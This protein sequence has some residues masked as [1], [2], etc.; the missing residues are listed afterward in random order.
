MPL[1]TLFALFEPPPPSWQRSERY[2]TVIEAFKVGE[3]DSPGKSL[4]ARYKLACKQEKNW[5]HT[6]VCPICPNGL[7]KPE[8]MLS[9]DCTKQLWGSSCIHELL[10]LN[11]EC[12]ICFTENIFPIHVEWF[13][14]N[15]LEN[16][17]QLIKGRRETKTRK[18]LKL[19][20]QAEEAAYHTR[21][22]KI[23]SSR[24]TDLR[25]LHP[26]TFKTA[27][28]PPLPSGPSLHITGR[29]F[30]THGHPTERQAQG[31]SSSSISRQSRTQTQIP[32]SSA[33]IEIS[34]DEEERAKELSKAPKTENPRKKRSAVS[35]GG[36]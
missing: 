2:D 26:P 22:H 10:Q 34:S 15:P 21:A 18:R 28:N 33:V 36:D 14:G 25:P 9:C 20:A 6:A 1:C 16:A 32:R 17:K 31:S 3:D 29:T 30:T 8:V 7:V 13:K 4:F 5:E 27:T 12:P 11:Q 23:I 19:R 24:P 35:I